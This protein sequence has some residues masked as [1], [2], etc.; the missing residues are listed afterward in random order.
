[1]NPV[2]QIESGSVWI[3]FLIFEIVCDI[4]HVASSLQDEIPAAGETEGL[5]G[6]AMNEPDKTV[7]CAGMAVASGVMPEEHT[8]K[9]FRAFAA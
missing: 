6:H 5:K 1:M 7:E 4:D 3:V 2:A 9:R 8:A